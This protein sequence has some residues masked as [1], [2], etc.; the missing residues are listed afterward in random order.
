M[1]FVLQI[2]S[3]VALAFLP[4]QLSAQTIR[5]RVVDER[6]RQPVAGVA[7]VLLSTGGGVVADANSDA[8]GF[9]ALRVPP[10]TYTLHL[11]RIGYAS[12]DSELRIGEEDRVLPAFVLKAE[13]IPLDSIVAEVPSRRPRNEVGFRRSANVISGARLAK[14]EEVAARPLTAVHELP[15]VRIRRIQYYRGIRD[16]QCIES[17]RR[18]MSMQSQGGGCDPAVLVLDGIVAGDPWDG[19]RGLHVSDIESIEFLSPVEAGFQW[20]GNAAVVGAL[21]VWTRGQGPYRSEAR[22]IKR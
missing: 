19:I 12:I 14:L 1:S 18:M 7:A 13:V 10:G 4:L 3:M 2:L 16:Y 9:F 22:N 8:D 6:S 20:G 5:G 15:N 17:P 21:V 11:Q